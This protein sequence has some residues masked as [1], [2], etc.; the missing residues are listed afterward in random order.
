MPTPSDLHVDAPLTNVSIAYLQNAASFIAGRVFPTLPVAKQSDKYYK[1]PKGAWHRGGAKKRGPHSESA[2]GDWDVE[3]AT[4][5]ADVWAHHVDIDDQERANAD[6]VFNLNSDA[7]EFNAH[8]LLVRREIEWASTYFAASVWDSDQTGVAATPGAN[9]FLQWNDAASTPIEDVRAQRR[10]IAKNTGFA[11]NTLVLGPEVFDTLVD[12][13]DIVDRIKYTQ[14]GIVTPDLLA[15]VFNVSRVFVPES[16][17]NT[18]TEGATDSMAH[19]FGKSALLVYSAPTP[20]LRR[21]SG[22]Y[23]FAW[24]GLVGS[25]NTGF[26]TKRFRIEQ[27]ASDRIEGEMAWDQKLVAADLGRFFASAV[28]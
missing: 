19:V 14:T 6:S 17:K 5:F 13:A 7:A 21:P 12:H 9:Q 25:Q 26:R 3:T 18:A 28:A 4:Y 20:G 27:I 8:Q 15:N 1:Y 24:S 22:G 23:T 16:I 11:P 2:G 10:A